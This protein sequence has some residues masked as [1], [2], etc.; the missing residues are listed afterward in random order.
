MKYP[1]S[2]MYVKP[3]KPIIQ[4]SAMYGYSYPPYGYYPGTPSPTGFYPPVVWPYNGALEAPTDPRLLQ[5]MNNET[6]TITHRIIPKNDKSIIQRHL[7][8]YFLFEIFYLSS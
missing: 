7:I 1:S 8:I 2:S 4:D 3:T 5:P 6:K